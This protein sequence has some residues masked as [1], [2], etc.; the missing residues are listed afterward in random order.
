MNRAFFDSIDEVRARA[1]KLAREN[2]NFL[3]R[4]NGSFQLC[5]TEVSCGTAAPVTHVRV[6]IASG[7]GDI[8]TTV[9]WEIPG[10]TS[11]IVPDL[12]VIARETPGFRNWVNCGS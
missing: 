7:P 10:T 11:A 8:S 3:A 4:E 5:V 2:G 12:E 1:E 9:M 6:T